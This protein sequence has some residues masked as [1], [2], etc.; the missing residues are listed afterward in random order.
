MKTNRTI[1]CPGF[2]I[3]IFSFAC[4]IAMAQLKA[5]FTSNV[6]SGCAP[7]IVAFQDNS[8]GNPTKW[9]WSLG[10]GTIAS[11]QNPV[12]TYFDA[13]TYTVKLTVKNASGADS[14]S[15]ITYITVYANPQLAFSASPTEGCYPLD[16]KFTNSSKAGSGTISTYLWDFGDGNI[17]STAN[18]AHTYIS[19]GTFDVTLKVTNSFGCYNAVTKSDL[20]QINDGVNADF[21]LTSLNVCNIPAAA[22]FKNLSK[23]SGAITYLWNFGDGGTSQAV[24]PTHN[25]T[26]SGNF[27]VV[28]T[29]Q[30]SSGCSDTASFPLVVHFPV[31]SFS[32]TAATCLN[33]SLHFTNTSVPAPISSTWYFGDGTTSSDMNPD[34]VYNKTGDY[35]VK[36]VNV[37]SAGCSDSV[38]NTITIA[39]GPTASFTA[40]DTSKCIAP[41]TVNFT[42]KTTGAATEFLW[43]FGDG[44]T[45]SAVNP[46]YTYNQQGNFTVTLTAIN[47]NGCQATF[48]KPKYISILPLK[49]T[50]LKNLPDSGCVPLIVNPSIIL[51]INSKI[52]KYTWDFGDGG[53][54]S[55][56]LPTHTYTKEGFFSVKVTIETEDGCTDSY[57]LPNAVLAGHKPK[58]SFS[59]TFDSICAN[60]TQTYQNTSTNGPITFLQWNYLQVVDSITGE[61]FNVNPHDT[62]YR[63]VTLVAF[64][65][66]CS[67]TIVKYREVYAKPPLAKIDFQQHCDNRLLVNFIDSSILDVTQKW[68]FGDGTSDISKNPVHTYSAPGNY[69]V[70]LYTTNKT[71]HDTATATIKLINEVG[72]ISL[73]DSVYCRGN[74]ISADIKGINLANIKTTKWD[75]GDGTII[76][77]NG[78]TKTSHAYLVNG[79]FKVKATMTDKNKCQYIYETK[80]SITIYGPLATFTSLTPG[81]CQNSTVVFT[82]KSSQD[83]IHNIIKW[84]WNYGDDI[85][86]VYNTPSIFSHTY[87]D[88][89]HYSV[90]LKVTDD[91]G[92]SD[93]LKKSNYVFISHPNASFII[94]DSIACPGKQLSFQNTSMGENLNYLWD[95]DDGSQSDKQNPSHTYKSGIYNPELLVTD[96]NNCTDSFHLNQLKISA[97]VAKFTLSDSVST[98][99]PLQ[100][101]F[102]N[103]STDFENVVWDFGDGSPSLIVSPTHLYTYPGIYPV[104]LIVNGYGSCADTAAIQNITIKGPTGKM[105]YKSTPV[106]YPDTTQFSSS[107]NNTVLYTWDF[108]DGNT[109]TTKN[110]NISYSYQ[111]GN[112]LPKLILQDSL[113]CKVSIKGED[114][115]KIYDVKANANVIGS[116]S[117]NLT[118]VQFTDLSAS[119]D[120]IIH[121]Y[122][123]FGDDSSAD[124]K[125]VS[126]IYKK[127]GVYNAY[128][129]AETK[130]GCRDTFNIAAGVQI[131]PTP[132]INIA[133]DSVACAMANVSFTGSSST[134]DSTIIWTWNFGNGKTSTGKEVVTTYSSGNYTTQLI[135][136]NSG[137]CADTTTKEIIVNALPKVKAG[138]DTT[139]CQSSAYQLNASGAE[140]YTWA[141]AG[142]SCISCDAPLIQ[143]DTTSTYFVMGKDAAGCI[144]S[145]SVNISVIVPTK[146]NVAGIDS[147][148]AGQ[149]VQFEASGGSTYQWY[150]SLYLDDDKSSQPFFTAAKDTSLTYKVVGYTAQQCFADTEY[151][152]VKVFAI[153]QI[154]IPQDEIVLNIGSSI[155][156]NAGSSSGITSWDWQP[157]QGLSN[158]KIANPIAS[159]VQTTT[160][161]CVA[162]NGGSCVARDEITIRVICSNANV[163]IPNTFSPNNDGMNDIFYP[164]GAGLVNIKSF[165]I[166]N[167]WGQLIFERFNTSPNN[168]G[169]GW[170]GTYNGKPSASDVYI[171]MIEAECANNLIIPFKGN[172]TLIK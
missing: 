114:T 8:T 41:L 74:N 99:P 33:Q 25:Y 48:E 29:A 103:K 112:Y 16:V 83:G 68:D 87:P 121:H 169:E 96:I 26:A 141:G 64:N 167:R 38:T 116:I 57:T 81:S 69:T 46:T 171:Y 128:L 105:I 85:E 144:G 39:T 14:I 149:T 15:K 78:G 92:C 150:P 148:C 117:C 43:D 166:F 42:N 165:R 21:N 32:H 27:N 28:L 157:P 134:Q 23:G 52:K 88:T 19:S 146:I 67:D 20:I 4:N 65:Y 155:Q 6:Q 44:N 111:P 154:N 40:D 1:V 62:G 10:N 115:V 120:N 156:L 161:S 124:Q 70:I 3:L 131:L 133:G 49:I 34:K 122:W 91:Y 84:S 2:F 59:G 129:I 18:S 72:T 54:S 158:N 36:L 13:G 164:I 80:D 136:S 142:L 94:S 66:G 12:T 31:S 151:F 79:R 101:D 55:D 51:N 75:F 53:S 97:P 130:T 73:T 153:P 82:D 137:G 37:F 35:T 110:K 160:Y 172:I 147:L 159:P 98:C 7:L 45:S 135:G 143:P 113:G 61:Y 107:A 108:S 125:S 76:T 170:N 119:E 86:H 60:Q 56:A 163:Y 123:F 22:S 63:N 132:Q 168:A 100:V 102:T 5:D 139:V 17:D 126:H 93:S 145:D 47:S 152:S 138:K 71:C 9:S 24:S 104:K 50:G 95:F 58:A 109:I 162:S 11:N 140:T 118:P 90:R 77:I 106:C 127:P 30:T 89:G